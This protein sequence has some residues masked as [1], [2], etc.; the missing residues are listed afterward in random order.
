MVLK[1]VIKTR[2]SQPLFDMGQIVTTRTIAES[3]EPEKVASFLRDHV[4]CNTSQSCLC[5]EDLDMNKAAIKNGDDRVFSAFMHQGK[6]LYVITEWD[7]SYTTVLFA[8]E[9]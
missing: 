5:N 3:V 6:K 2:S 1:G 7:R 9:Y 8:D 4:T